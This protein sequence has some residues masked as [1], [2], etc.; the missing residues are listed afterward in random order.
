MKAPAAK[1]L[2]LRTEVRRVLTN[3]Q[4]A[5]GTQA[6]LWANKLPEHIS[7]AKWRRN[8]QQLLSDGESSLSASCLARE[9]SSRSCERT[10]SNPRMNFKTTYDNRMN[11]SSNWT[12]PCRPPPWQDRNR[13]YIETHEPQSAQSKAHTTNLAQMILLCLRQRCNHQT[14]ILCSLWIPE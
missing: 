1:L 3:A 2:R 9:C 4:Q 10:G 12:G 14:T 13:I 6:Q 8:R 7:A 5:Q 11:W